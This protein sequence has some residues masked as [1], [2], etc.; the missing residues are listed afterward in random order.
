MRTGVHVNLLLFSF[1]GTDILLKN[2][3]VVINR[4][5]PVWCSGRHRIYPSCKVSVI[6]VWWSPLQNICLKFLCT[7]IS[8]TVDFNKNW[9]RMISL[10]NFI[11]FVAHYTI[12]Y[13]ST[14]LPFIRIIS[15]SLLVIILYFDLC[16]WTDLPIFVK[17]IVLLLNIIYFSCS[18]WARLEVII[19]LSW[20][21][22]HSCTNS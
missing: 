14:C 16:K 18:H 5:V 12:L 19:P 1:H 7:S 11:I 21:Q 17:P 22:P 13:L 20:P 2:T 9:R 8:F 4:A 10:P 6:I 15:A 3:D